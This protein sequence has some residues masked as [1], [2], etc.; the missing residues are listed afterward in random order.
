MLFGLVAMFP[1]ID[2]L[3]SLVPVRFP[4]LRI[5]LAESGIGWVNA[6]VD[7]LEH[8]AR[9]HECYGDWTGTDLSPA[10]VFLR[11]FWFCA[12]DN[13]SAFT[14]E[15]LARMGSDRVLLETD[16]PHAD[17]SWPHTQELLRTQL[18]D[19]DTGTV[20][21]ITWRNAAELFAHPVPAAVASDP[22]AF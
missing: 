17:S 21:R 11:N 9:Y 19:L 10:E 7:R 3:F 16:Y 18:E 6:M 4:G 5:L 1:A 13:P 20:E 12:L 8:V 14:A 22:D 2:W 15:S